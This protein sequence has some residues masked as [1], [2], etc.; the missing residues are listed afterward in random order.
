MTAYMFRYRDILYACLS[1]GPTNWLYYIKRSFAFD[2]SVTV[3]IKI[4][5]LDSRTKSSR[6]ASSLNFHFEKQAIQSGS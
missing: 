4:E 6:E 3:G 1:R 2:S 5:C